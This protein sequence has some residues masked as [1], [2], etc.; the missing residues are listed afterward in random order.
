MWLILAPRKPPRQKQ[1]G[2][3]LHKQKLSRLQKG[4]RLP[5]QNVL[6]LLRELRRHRPRKRP[7][8]LKLKPREKLLLLRHRQ[9]ERQQLQRLKQREK[10]QRLKLSANV[11]RHR[12]NVKLLQRRRRQSKQSRRLA[13]VRLFP[14]LVSDKRVKVQQRHHLNPHQRLGLHHEV[15]QPFRSG[16][17]IAMVQFL[18]S[19]QDRL[20]LM[21]VMQSRRL[22]LQRVTWLEEMWFRLDQDQ[23]TT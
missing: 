21:M 8:L 19:S 4:L 12:R 18:V 5:T 17:K 3:P 11:K 1:R 14:Y 16:A 9:R 7:Q 13:L 22:L 15:Y 23:D 20:H 6:P 2:R 10:Q